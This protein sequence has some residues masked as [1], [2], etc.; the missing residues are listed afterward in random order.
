MSFAIIN[1]RWTVD[2]HGGIS[3]LACYEMGIVDEEENTP[4]NVFMRLLRHQRFEDRYVD[5]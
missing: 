5:H 1:W 2:T 3:E 4:L